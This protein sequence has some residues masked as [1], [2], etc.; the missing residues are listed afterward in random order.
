MRCLGVLT[1]TLLLA[2]ICQ[3]SKWNETDFVRVNGELSVLE[4]GTIQTRAYDGMQEYKS[5]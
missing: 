4:Q 5:I 2:A 3:S 1:L